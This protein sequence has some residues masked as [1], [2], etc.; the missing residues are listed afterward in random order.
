MAGLVIVLT[1]GCGYVG[2]RMVAKMAREETCVRELRVVD[3]NTSGYR[4]PEPTNGMKITVM[5]G[6]VR[7]E[8]RMLEVCTGADVII[9]T[10]ALLD[11]M[12]KFPDQVVWD[13]NVKGTEVMLRSCLAADVPF[14]INVSSVEAFGPNRRG[15]PVPDGDE[16]TPY[17]SS[18][19]SFFYATTKAEAED[20]VLR[21]DGRRT[22]GGRTLRTCSLRPM[23]MYGEGLMNLFVDIERAIAN[24]QSSYAIANDKTQR[25]TFVYLDNFLHALRLTLDRLVAAPDIVGGQV[26]FISDDT[27][28]N[29]Y[30]DHR[31][32]FLTAIGFTPE[33]KPFLPI[34]VLYALGLVFEFIRWVLSPVYNF[35]PPWTSGLILVSNTTMCLRYDKATRHLG[36]RPVVPWEEAKRRTVDWIVAYW[37]S[38]QGGMAE[39]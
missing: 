4:A 9:H 13:I 3:V 12:G 14:F 38:R 27:P 32:N 1:G 34:R 25:C 8:A 18:T 29:N 7:D 21:H 17:D 37:A 11:F 26:Y 22:A 6:D 2:S 39:G 28:V 31:K 10:A 19:H 33:E 36:Y 23:G 20:R 15:D 5:Q 35:Q 24:K 16:E 30:V